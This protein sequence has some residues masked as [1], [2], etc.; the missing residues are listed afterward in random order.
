MHAYLLLDRSGSMQARWEETMGA[1]NA[2]VQ[3]LSIDPATDDLVTLA[4][5]DSVE[6]LSYNVVR[7]RIHPTEW[8]AVTPDEASPRGQTPLFDAIGRMVADVEADG[9]EKAL[10]AVITDGQENDSREVTRALA[11]AALERCD[12]RGWQTVFL[13]ADFKN[14]ADGEAMQRAPRSM[15]GY[16]SSKAVPVF[17]ELGRKAK[18]YRDVGIRASFTP[19]DR[20]EAEEDDV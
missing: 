17:T 12:A 4:V 7:R 20:H 19:S 6:R 1:V 13:G 11:K 14:F 2:F 16:K 9:P 3:E 15:M 10:I 8:R 18:A 5:F